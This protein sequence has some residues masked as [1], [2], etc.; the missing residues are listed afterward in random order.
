[1]TKDG[2]K[3]LVQAE[4]THEE[5]TTRKPAARMLLL[6]TVGIGFLVALASS[7]IKNTVSAFFVSMATEFDVSRGVFAVAPSIFMLTYA[8]ASPTMGYVADR[9]G[10]RRTL[11]GGLLLGGALFVS[12]GIVNSFA[13]F[14][15]VYGIGMAIAYTAVSFVPLGVLVDE[16]FPPNRRGIVYAILMNGAAVGFIVLLPL[17][18]YLDSR[19]SWR[20]VFVLLGAAMVILT[21]CVLIFMRE[22]SGQLTKKSTKTPVSGDTRPL[23]GVFKSPVF[24]SVSI[25][26]FGCGVTMGFIDVHFVAHLDHV[27]LGGS[28]AEL[29]VAM[30]G[31]AEIIGALLAGFLCDRG[32]GVAV[33]SGSYLI[34]AA[35]F[36]ALAI[37]PT[38]LTA[39]GFGVL[40]GVSYLG[41]V[42]AGTMFLLNAPDIES[43]GLALGLM[44]FVHQIGAFLSSQLGG[45]GYDLVGSYTPTMVGSAVFAIISFLI[46]VLALPRSLSRSAASNEK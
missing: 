44:W 18:I 33:L 19:V 25:A 22:R 11:A 34:R 17:W 2:E 24:R 6:I 12:G 38:V 31:I 42:I 7:S 41:T 21:L 39:W 46:V 10:A 3:A 23:I 26:F 45:I 27:N 37:A 16:L 28:N 4:R 8:V 36:I 40:F 30:L 15:A 5:A 1:M 43:K 14:S 13:L 29:T 32:A 9:F 35:S 20:T